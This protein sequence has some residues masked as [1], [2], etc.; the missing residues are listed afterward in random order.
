MLTCLF[1]VTGPALLGSMCFMCLFPC[2]MVRSM[3]SHAYILGF[4][5]FH[6]FMLTSTCLD[7]HSHAYKHIFMRICLDLCFHMFVC[8]DL[9]SLH[10]LCHFPHVLV[11]HAMFVYLDLGYVCHA[12]CYCSPFVAL[13]FFLVSWPNG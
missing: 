13:S 4:V 6:A 5:F 1:D 11:P 9:R 3:F 10:A 12:I 2:Y 8:L 7:V